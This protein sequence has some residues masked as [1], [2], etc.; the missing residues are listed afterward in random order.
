MLKL[1]GTNFNCEVIEQHFKREG[2]LN[3]D[4]NF[5]QF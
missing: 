5:R 3:L 2:M 1:A 4:V